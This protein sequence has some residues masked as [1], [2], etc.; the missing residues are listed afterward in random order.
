MLFAAAAT[1]GGN[2]LPYLRVQTRIRK[3]EAGAA[4]RR[5]APPAQK[6]NIHTRQV[7]QE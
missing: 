3:H 5:R 2:F 1:F 4:M 7:V 6:T